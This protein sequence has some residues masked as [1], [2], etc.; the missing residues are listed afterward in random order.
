MDVRHA[1]QKCYYFSPYRLHNQI[2]SQGPK[3]IAAAAAVRAQE[4]KQSVCIYYSKRLL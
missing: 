1:T 4:S 2:V 3:E